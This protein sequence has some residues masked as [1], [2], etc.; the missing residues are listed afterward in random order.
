[1]HDKVLATIVLAIEPSLLY[2]TGSGP[3]DLVVVWKALADQFQCKTWAIKLELKRKLFLIKLTKGGAVQDHINNMKGICD[4]L[5]VRR[6]E[7]FICWLVCQR[8]IM[9][10]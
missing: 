9:F 4:E 3:T 10:L 1:M 5:S 8:V 6:T 7:L 2:L